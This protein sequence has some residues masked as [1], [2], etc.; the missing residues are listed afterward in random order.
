[1]A[2]SG[3]FPMPRVPLL[4]PLVLVVLAL[5][6]TVARGQQPADTDDEAECRAAAARYMTAFDA[7]DAEALRD[8]TYYDP[9]INAQNQGLTAMI[10]CVVAQRAFDTAV[11]ARWGPNAARY[12]IDATRFTAE[13]HAA[14]PRARFQ[15]RGVTDAI[16]VTEGNVAP[17]VL[18]RTSSGAK[19]RVVVR[20]I[21]L[22]YDTPRRRGPEIGSAKRINA[23]TAVEAALRDITA[24]I[25]AGE[26]ASAD[27]A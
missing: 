23:M 18:R 14:L 4:R 22:L 15:L 5:S 17:I 3:S 25:G 6:S 12:A 16:L 13:E 20:G 26:F 7:G 11:A 1:M 9:E 10:G 19:W 24:R 8:V 21:T 27:A 2:S